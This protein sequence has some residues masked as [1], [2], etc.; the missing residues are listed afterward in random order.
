MLSD[1]LDNANM[2]IVRDYA[3][4]K[5]VHMMTTSKTS[6]ARTMLTQGYTQADVA[7][8]LGVSLT[9]LKVALKEG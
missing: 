6:R 9:T 4:P 2:K 1:I 3:T 8:Q 7:A 5:R